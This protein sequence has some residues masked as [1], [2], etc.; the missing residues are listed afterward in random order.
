[1]AANPF[2]VSGRFESVRVRAGFLLAAIVILPCASAQDCQYCLLIVTAGI[3]I[4]SE[5]GSGRFWLGVNLA[6][7]AALSLV[8]FTFLFMAASTVLL[9]AWNQ[10]AV[11]RARS[12]G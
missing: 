9:I 11:Q 5:K 1:M 12:I 4:L 10:F 3:L 7:L 8:K 2:R 6:A